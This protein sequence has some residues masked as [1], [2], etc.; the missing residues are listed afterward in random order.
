MIFYTGNEKLCSGGKTAASQGLGLPV[1]S[2]AYNRLQV[3]QAVA[4]AF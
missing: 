3:F 1:L 4:L 2:R